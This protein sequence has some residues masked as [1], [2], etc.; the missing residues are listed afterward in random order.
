MACG[1][2]R[3]LTVGERSGTLPPSLMFPPEINIEVNLPTAWN[4]R[5]YMFGNGG[6]AG[7]SFAAAAGV[8]ARACSTRR[9]RW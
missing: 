2:L 8:W 9:P 7:E 4:G 6:W 1:E 3:G 5:L